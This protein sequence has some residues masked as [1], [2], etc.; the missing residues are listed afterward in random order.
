MSVY[1][2]AYD[3]QEKVKESHRMTLAIGIIKINE[4]MIK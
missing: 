4:R 3:I 2:G 1:G